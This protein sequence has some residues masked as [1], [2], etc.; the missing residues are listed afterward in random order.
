MATDIQGMTP[1]S[2]LVMLNFN[3]ILSFQFYNL[4][5]SLFGFALC[6]GIMFLI[7]WKSALITFV[8]IF[9]LYLVVVYRKPG[10]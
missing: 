4:W 7:D 10:K 8:I 5:L 2:R 9:A 6:V 1:L 3:Q